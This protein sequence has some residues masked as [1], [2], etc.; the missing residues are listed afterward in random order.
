[1]TVKS[2]YEDQIFEIMRSRGGTA[3]MRTLANATGGSVSTINMACRGLVAAGRLERFVKDG[4]KFGY[5]IPG[6]GLQARIAE[7][8]AQ[9]ASLQARLDLAEGVA[10]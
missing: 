4:G 6:T 8:E 1:M 7:L 9:L 2:G 5:R 10:A 3:N